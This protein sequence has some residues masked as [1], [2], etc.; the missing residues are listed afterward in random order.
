MNTYLRDARHHAER[1]DYY[2]ARAGEAGYS[3]ARYHEQQLDELLIR[4]QRSK[5]GKDDVP[6]IKAIIEDARPKLIDMK[7]REKEGSKE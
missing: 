1:I 2:H 4:A 3:Q 6:V 7:R 5:R